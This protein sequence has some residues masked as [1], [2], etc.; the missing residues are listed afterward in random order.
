MD[1][2]HVIK[3]PLGGSDIFDSDGK[4]VGYSLPGV[5]GDGEDFYDMDG[6]PVGQS[7]DDRHGMSDFLG[8]GNGT[9]GYMDQEIL[10][11]R[12]A[13]LNGNPFEKE[14]DPDMPV[15]GDMPGMDGFDDGLDSGDDFGSGTDW[16]DCGPDF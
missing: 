15:P 11:G 8:V 1:R 6:N 2:F 5:F 13:W 10:M 14:E 12:N 7:F 4:Q 9:Y 3:H 16:G